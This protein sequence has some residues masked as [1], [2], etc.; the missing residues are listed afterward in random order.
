[1]VLAVIDVSEE[2]KRA[3]QVS[4]AQIVRPP[5]LISRN[6]LSPHK[7][8]GRSATLPA[9]YGQIL[10]FL[11]PIQLPVRRTRHPPSTSRCRIEETEV[12]SVPSRL[13]S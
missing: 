4:F 6:R 5:T 7:P 13:R 12:S 9:Q 11:V 8:F 3:L 1:V 2:E 10:Q